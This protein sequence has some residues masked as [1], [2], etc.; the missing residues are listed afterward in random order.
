ML[1]DEDLHKLALDEESV[2]DAIEGTI[3]ERDIVD[4]LNEIEG[5]VPP[6]LDGLVE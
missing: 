1:G 3:D 2:G 5:R 6:E 4:L